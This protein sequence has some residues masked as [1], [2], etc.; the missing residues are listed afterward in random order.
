MTQEEKAKAYD[1]A[2]ERAKKVHKYS[3]DIAEIK[4][5]EEIFPE[6]LESEDERIKKELISFLQ[7][8][9]PQFVGK[10]K[11]EKWIAWLEK[12]GKKEFTF[13]SIPRLLE[14]IEPT[15]R[16]K[17]YCQK[18]IDSLVKEGYSTDAKVVGECLK[19]MNGED[20]PMAIMDEKKANV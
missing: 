19:Q 10:R 13:K 20:V 3:S 18:L 2:L 11:Q 8:P 5:M 1:E 9:H 12:Q 6:L 7:L 16:A 4:R 14:M 17:S 15:D